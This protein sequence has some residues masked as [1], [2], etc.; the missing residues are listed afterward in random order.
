MECTKGLLFLLHETCMRGDDSLRVLFMQ[1][2]K[3]A[4]N[5]IKTVGDAS[6]LLLLCRNPSKYSEVH[7]KLRLGIKQPASH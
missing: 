1:Y 3:V 7:Y 5:I 2:M 6:L 4:E